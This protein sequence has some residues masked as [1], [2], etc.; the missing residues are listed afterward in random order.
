MKVDVLEA[1]GGYKTQSRHMKRMKEWKSGPGVPVN[2]MEP[3][4]SFECPPSSFSG[5]Q[6]LHFHLTEATVWGLFIHNHQ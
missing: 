1:L 6:E 4:T 2:L 3:P 5:K